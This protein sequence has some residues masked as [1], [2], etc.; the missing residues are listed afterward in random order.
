MLKMWLKCRTG[1]K[2]KDKKSHYEEPDVEEAVGTPVAFERATTRGASTVQLSKGPRHQA[3]H[4]T[5][6]PRYVDDSPRYVDNSPRYVDDSP[7]YVENSPRFVPEHRYQTPPWSPHANGTMSEGTGRSPHVNGTMSEG[8]DSPIPFRVVKGDCA[9]IC[10][11]SSP[12]TPPSG[13]V[14]PSPPPKDPPTPK[15]PPHPR[16]PV[17]DVPLSPITPPGMV[18]PPPRESPHDFREVVKCPAK[19][20]PEPIPPPPVESPETPDEEIADPPEH[21]PI[22]KGSCVQVHPKLVH[23]SVILVS[24]QTVA[25]SVG[26]HEGGCHTV[27]NLD[28]PDR[29]KDD[30]GQGQSNES[31]LCLTFQHNV[32]TG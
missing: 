25:A 19:C 13:N 15:C 29:Y 7:R 24:H 4:H 12:M 2:R 17:V 8:N 23:D 3:P 5:D 22:V 21:H 11:P 32:F 10:S 1:L 27:E 14:V 26:T 28:S 16:G 6:S 31:V 9:R 18:Y 30:Y 20:R